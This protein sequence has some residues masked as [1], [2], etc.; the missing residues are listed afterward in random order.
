MGGIKK[1]RMK[2]QK[3][4]QDDSMSR[5]GCRVA[6]LDSTNCTPK[7]SLPPTAGIA[8]GVEKGNRY[9]VTILTS[10]DLGCLKLDDEEDGKGGEVDEEGEEEADVE[11]ERR[12]AP[13]V[14]HPK[15]QKHL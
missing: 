9:A 7:N 12:E 11:E 10:L 15:G 4:S 5:P 8:V 3:W 2:H 13:E 6:C 14:V 1:E